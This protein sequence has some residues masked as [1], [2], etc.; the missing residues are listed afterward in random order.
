MVGF[1]PSNNLLHY[2]LYENDDVTTLIT[3][4]PCTESH[5]SFYPDKSFV[6]NT[7]ALNYTCLP[8]NQTI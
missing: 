3:L 2:V 7:I 1:E 6:R 4:E 8:L 5:F